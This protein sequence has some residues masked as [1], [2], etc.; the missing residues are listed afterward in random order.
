MWLSYSAT[1]A[2][3]AATVP[4]GFHSRCVNT[5]QAPGVFPCHSRPRVAGSPKLLKQR[6]R[7]S[8][9]AVPQR[10]AFAVS[11][12]PPTLSADGPFD[13]EP[14]Q[15]STL[16][17]PLAPP[18][19]QR[20]GSQG[21]GESPAQWPG[22]ELRVS[23]HSPTNPAAEQYAW[24]TEPGTLYWLVT[25]CEDDCT[26][27]SNEV[28]AAVRILRAH[29]SGSR[30][31]DTTDTSSWNPENNSWPVARG[32]TPSSSSSSNNNNNIFWSA[33]DPTQ[34]LIHLAGAQNHAMRN[35]E[36][37]SICTPGCPSLFR[38]LFP[39]GP[40]PLIGVANHLFVTTQTSSSYPNS[41]PLW[42]GTQ[43]HRTRT[44]N[45]TSPTAST[46]SSWCTWPSIRPH[47]S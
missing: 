19:A 39:F 11:P 47:V 42:T 9:V 16:S 22:F 40:F 38:N 33:A 28:H 2:T 35:S 32:F 1:R 46:R 21:I 10:P 3:H 6:H 15:Q 24:S 43:T 18:W 23:S 29:R 34:G 5:S 12:F 41:R 36:L 27:H 13:T 4:G 25:A 44:S 14:F 31:W 7:V 17:Q 30:H 45:T 8:A 37:L 20:G 26:Q